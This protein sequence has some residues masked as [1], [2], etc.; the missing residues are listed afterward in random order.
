MAKIDARLALAEEMRQLLCGIEYEAATE[1]ADAILA[2]G[3]VI[4]ADGDIDGEAL[5]V[6]IETAEDQL[7]AL[8]L[9][10]EDCLESLI[11]LRDVAS[12]QGLINE[13]E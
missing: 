11:S 12:K 3:Q 10:C 6:A 2:I 13:D 7:R 5:L 9:V 8:I 1:S 4:V